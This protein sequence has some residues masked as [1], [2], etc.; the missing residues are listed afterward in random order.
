M[1]KKMIDKLFGNNTISQEPN[2]DFDRNDLQEP[3]CP[4][5]DENKIN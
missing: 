2:T 3:N 5:V 1:I 4:N